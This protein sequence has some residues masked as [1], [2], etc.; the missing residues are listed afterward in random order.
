MDL[1]ISPPPPFH[2]FPGTILDLDPALVKNRVA[3]WLLEVMNTLYRW[4][5]FSLIPVHVV[6]PV[7]LPMPCPLHRL[8]LMRL[9]T[10]MEEHFP[11]FDDA[12]Y[13]LR[14]SSRTTGNIQESVV[15]PVTFRPESLLVAVIRHF[16]VSSSDCYFHIKKLLSLGAD[17]DGIT[18]DGPSWI[19]PLVA[20]E[21]YCGDDVLLRDRL[22]K[23]LILYHADVNDTGW[24][25][26]NVLHYRLHQFCY[27]STAD[28]LLSFIRWLNLPMV[29]TDVPVFQWHPVTKCLS[30]LDYVDTIL[31]SV[32]DTAGSSAVQIENTRTIVHEVLYAF[33]TMMREEDA[34][35]LPSLQDLLGEERTTTFYRERVASFWQLSWNQVE[36]EDWRRLFQ[37]MAL[38]TACPEHFDAFFRSL[39]RP[40]E[41]HRKSSMMV[42]S[43]TNASQQEFE[44][45]SIE[46]NG[47]SRFPPSWLVQIRTPDRRVYHVW[48]GYLQVLLT[49]PVLPSTGETIDMEERQ[50]L[51]CTYLSGHRLLH[52]WKQELVLPDSLATVLQNFREQHPEVPP[53]D[54]PSRFMSAPITVFLQQPFVSSGGE[55]QPRSAR[56][57]DASRYVLDRI[58]QWIRKVHPYSNFQQLLDHRKMS[59]IRFWKYLIQVLAHTPSIGRSSSLSSSDT[60]IGVIALLPFE[61][62][63]RD[64]MGVVSPSLRIVL[65]TDEISSLLRPFQSTGN[66]DRTA[67]MDILAWRAVFMKCV[68]LCTRT[69]LDS[70]HYRFE[71]EWSI[72]DFF[73]K[74]QHRYGNSSIQEQ[75]D[76]FFGDL[77]DFYTQHVEA[78]PSTTFSNLHKKISTL[79]SVFPTTP[80]R[81][82]LP[83]TVTTV[84]TT[85]PSPSSLENN[86]EGHEEEEEEF[87][88]GNQAWV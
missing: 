51:W 62:W 16:H 34:R 18:A 40:I 83:T 68:Y 80:P 47:P 71:E 1:V 52:F 20:A 49:H 75:S 70:M 13:H 33:G 41:T 29:N 86:D 48:G 23:L 17:P 81:C 67:A 65:D 24:C 85:T 72:I 69:N 4:W 22:Q 39:W 27:A 31:E 43:T 32:K 76:A 2:P 38:W 45:D 26:K 55:G 50:R 57:H 42:S 37:L 61:R 8:S 12:Y 15:T 54:L 7:F 35:T 74:C 9:M 64:H 79:L 28:N 73:V 3:R 46:F 6:Y 14:I 56:D 63:V 66:D 44:M 77:M 53:K 78:Y 5:L 30:I 21:I 19:T 88:F 60:N 10:T 84:T 58:C 59:S 11:V 82:P 87:L 36:L 25:G